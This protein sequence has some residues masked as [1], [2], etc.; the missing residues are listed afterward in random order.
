MLEP[1]DE[2]TEL[3]SGALAPEGKKW[4]SEPWQE[5]GKRDWACMQETEPI[6]LNDGVGAGDEGECN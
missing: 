2:K 4:W 3:E 6:V 1:D 5:H